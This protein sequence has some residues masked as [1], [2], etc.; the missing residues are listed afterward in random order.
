[1]ADTPIPAA[2]A[3]PAA[4]SQPAAD[5]SK[6]TDVV[7]QDDKKPVE[8]KDASASESDEDLED[9]ADA[10]DDMPDDT[11]EEKKA[12]AE[13]KKKWKLKVAGKDVEADEEELIKRAQ[14][15]YS[16]DQ[17][18]QEAAQMRKQ[19]ESFIGLLQSD[20]SEA[21]AQLGM[22]VDEL[23]ERHIQRRI[24]EM[25]K[26]PEQLEREKLEKE[27]QKLKKE[28]EDKENRAR[29]EEISRMQEKFAVE[30]ET[31]ILNALE[32]DK[33]MPNSPYV[34]KRVADLMIIAM[35]N[36]KKDVSA[37]DVLPLV[38][39]QIN[40]ELK[41]MYSLAP[42][43]VFE[44]LIGKDR[45]NKYR[46]ARVKRKPGEQPPPPLTQQVQSTGQKELKA[47]SSKDDKPKR[48]TRDFFKNLGK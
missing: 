7:P 40:Q 18:W 39:K 31:D 11:K 5:Q 4:S 32:K 42:D 3:A 14:M 45:L 36:G 30:I 28:M 47:Q 23:A 27:L 13:A 2:P 25:Q 21:L 26:S 46:K 8:A 22:N 29:E 1:M 33:E 15:G 37:K 38:K 43:D 41:D 34:V 19:M 20:P 16:A 6:K 10:I 35:Q 17:K 12:K 24:E 48:S 44:A 9:E